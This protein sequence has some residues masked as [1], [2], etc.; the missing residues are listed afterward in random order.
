MNVEQCDSAHFETSFLNSHT[1][2]LGAGNRV[3]RGILTVT[4][5]A[6]IIRG[7]CYH[8]V[9]DSEEEKMFLYKLDRQARQSNKWAAD[10]DL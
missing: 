5:A 2:I 9:C 8:A 10:R 6:D 4:Q 3:L 7:G 1:F